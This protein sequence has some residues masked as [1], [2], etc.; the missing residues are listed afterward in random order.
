VYP[1]DEYVDWTCLD[2]FNWGVR[3]GSP[4]WLSFNQVFRKT[5][6]QVVRLA[7]S[8]PMIIAE[9]GS[10]E[11]GGS[12]AAWIKN[13]LNVIPHHYKKIRGLIWFDVN[14]RGTGWPIE[15]SRKARRAFRAGVKHGVYR[16][17]FYANLPPGTVRPPR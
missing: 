6:R 2:G 8:K 4:G 15:T 14:D 3:H 17:N 12:K 11:K 1:G 10:S 7:P 13:A 5:Y 16:P 9:T